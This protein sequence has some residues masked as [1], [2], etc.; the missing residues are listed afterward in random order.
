MTS[1]FWLT[2]RAMYGMETGR[3]CRS[4]GEPIARRDAFGTSEG[5]C[6]RCRH[7]AEA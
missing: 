1:I 2:L 6:R 5:V 7:R 3:A 4:C